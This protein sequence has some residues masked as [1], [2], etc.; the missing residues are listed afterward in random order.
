MLGEALDK[1]TANRII[2][3]VFISLIL[4]WLVAHL[5]SLPVFISAVMSVLSPVLIGV[6]IAFIVNIPMRWFEQAFFSKPWKNADKQRGKMARPVSMILA[7]L[8]FLL[9]IGLVF[10]LLLPELVRT[11]TSFIG[12]LPDTFVRISNWF[13]NLTINND[14]PEIS[15]LFSSMSVSFNDIMQRFINW[16]TGALSGISSAVLGWIQSAINGVLNLFL[17]LIFSFYFLGFKET[18]LQEFKAIGFSALKESAMDKILTFGSLANVV[19]SNFFSGTAMEA[20]IL[21]ILTIIGMLIFNFPFALTISV[22]TGI[23]TFIPLMG[24][25]LSAAIG[26][27]LIAVEGGLIEGVL[28]VVFIIVMQQIE[29]NLIYPRVVGSSV[30]LSSFWTFTSVALGTSLFG[31]TGTILAVPVATII[32]LILEAWTELRLERKSVAMSKVMGTVSYAEY[33]IDAKGDSHVST[34]KMAANIVRPSNTTSETGLEPKTEVE[35]EAGLEPETDHES[36]RGGKSRPYVFD[37]ANLSAGDLEAE[38]EVDRDERRPNSLD[39]AMENLDDKLE[40]NQMIRKHGR[41]KPLKPKRL[42]EEEVD[43]LLVDNDEDAQDVQS[44][45]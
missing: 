3:I 2:G 28:F 25:F 38:L 1:K 26:F 42:L 12:E 36:Q 4:A 19:F 16:L 44:D 33:D 31:I 41:K 21:T 10:F 9:L 35:P 17:G 37:D 23:S 30:G 14:N 39:R 22:I 27:I 20:I 29:Y 13:D 5:S 34:K 40:K 32:Y 43:E 8:F 15:A 18:I 24:A 6:V 7:Y 11:I 45:V